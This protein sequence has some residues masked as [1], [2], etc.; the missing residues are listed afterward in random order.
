[1]ERPVFKAVGTPVE[2]LD[3]PALVVDVGSM[4]QNIDEVHGAFVNGPSLIRPDVHSHL[5]P[6]IAAMQLDAP[7]TVGGV[8]VSTVGEAEVFSENGVSDILIRNLLVTR[9]K[10]IRAC[11]VA[12][13]CSVTVV[14]ES[15]ANTKLLSEVA[16][17]AGV[18]LGVLAQVRSAAGRIG[19][20]SA[21]DALALT[22][23][24]VTHKGLAFKGLYAEGE[25]EDNSPGSQTLQTL[26][27]T[28]D[29]L[30]SS[31]INVPTVSVSANDALIRDGGA[32]GV[33]EVI[34]GAYALMDSRHTTYHSNLQNA[35]KILT[36]VITHPEPEVAWLDTGQKA[37]SIDTGLPAVDGVSGLS[38]SRMSAEHGGL[39]VE[40]DA[41]QSLNIGDK[42]W[43]I[44]S[45]IGNC[46]N[47]Y[48]FIHA[49]ENG[50]L[51]AVWDVAAR[52]QYS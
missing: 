13:R 41:Q 16:S 18:E 50:A 22:R 4:K 45:D 33:T 15:E 34:A 19:A 7:G 32:D 37:S 51:E 38:L 10:I 49:A 3:T 6:A 9:S 12:S 17:N 5:C 21:D 44:P 35:A 43:L 47:V 11:G 46:A 52:G 28:R 39:N 25:F 8:A 36:T 20:A 29:V 30:V 24:V 14:V 40:G 48:D 42:V 1:M 26:L 23:A 31:G 27:D 2:E